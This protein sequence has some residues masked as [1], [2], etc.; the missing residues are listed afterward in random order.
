MQDRKVPVVAIFAGMLVEHYKGLYTLSYFFNCI[1][2][3]FPCFSDL[4][5]PSRNLEI[6]FIVRST[7]ASKYYLDLDVEEVQKFHARCGLTELNHLYLSRNTDQGYIRPELIVLCVC[8][9]DGPHKPIDRL[10]CRLQKPV[11]PTE[12]VDSWRTIK[13]LTSLNSDELEVRCRPLIRFNPY[14]LLTYLSLFLY[15]SATG[16]CAEPP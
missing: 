11:N 7:S 15:S 16:F 10:P 8:S 13:Q 9:L 2:S 14:V 1:I 3:S 4:I 6:G 5:S 12:L